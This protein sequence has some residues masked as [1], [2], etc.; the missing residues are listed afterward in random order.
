VALD[1]AEHVE[2]GVETDLEAGNFDDCVEVSE[3][4]PL[5]AGSESTKVYCPGVGL[6]IDND[7]EATAVE[8]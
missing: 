4:T 3:T 5:E 6:V 8:R 2:A 7:L 1:R